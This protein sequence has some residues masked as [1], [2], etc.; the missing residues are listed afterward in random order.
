MKR[1]INGVFF[2]LGWTLE[3]PGDDDWTLT[4]CFFRHV[5]KERFYAIEEDRRRLAMREAMRPLIEHHLMHDM[6]EENTRFIGYYHDL[7]ERLSLGLSGQE[8]AEIAADHTY[9]FENYRVFDTSLE[10]LAVLKENGYRI[11]VISDTWPSTIPQQ[12]EAGLWEYYD[13]TVLSFELGVVKPH[14]RMYETALARMGLPG[15]ETLYADDL[16]MSLDKA[17]TYGIHGVRS[18][19]PDPSAEDDTYPCIARPL[20]ILDVI[21]A[22]NGGEL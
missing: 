17:G 15:E 3:R 10:T 8:I 7:S 6:E 21:K 5:P 18:I 22:M 9:N 2:D 12:K 11:G 20:D 14:P 13:C 19:A 16:T 1:R 4:A